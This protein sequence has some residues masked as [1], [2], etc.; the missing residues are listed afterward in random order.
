MLRTADIQIR[1]PFILQVDSLFYMFGTTDSSPWSGPGTGFNCYS[2]SDLELWD[3]P[4]A[5]FTPPKDFWGVTNYWAPEV[6][7]VGDQFFMTATFCANSGSRGTAI[8][9]SDHPTGPYLP[10]SD[11]PVTPPDWMCL[12][13]TLFEQAGQM[14]LAFCREWTEVIDGQIYAQ[15]LSA[16]L[17]HAIGHP[18]LLFSA[19]QAPWA[20][21]I[22]DE[23]TQGVPSFVTDGPFLHG[24]SDGALLM[25][26]SSFGQGGYTV[27]LVRSDSGLLA[28]PWTHLAD[29]LWPQDGGHGMLFFD[30][31]GQLQLSLHAPNDTPL[32][33]AVFHPVQEIADPQHPGH[34]TLACRQ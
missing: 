29:P 23:R 32:E 17:T 11:G 28:G 19:S 20:R 16:D 25:M 30:P 22:T 7:Q 9:V 14:W 12:D 21:P 18:Q 15:Q 13:G 3:G 6:K 31:T 27:G 8:L 4:F 24:L 1:D 26:W 2:S 34:L 10:H 33:R 5:A